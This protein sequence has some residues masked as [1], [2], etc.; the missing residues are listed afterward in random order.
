MR[1]LCI[2]ALCIVLLLCTAACGQTVDEPYSAAFTIRPPES[3]TAVYFDTPYVSE[4]F[5][6]RDDALD[7]NALRELY[8]GSLFG[9]ETEY[10]ARWST[11]LLYALE[12]EFTTQDAQTMSAL[13]VELARTDGFPGMRET[14]AA[15]ANVHIRFQKSD[16]PLF[17]YDA[18]AS[19]RIRSVEITVPSAYLP[20]QRN[21]IVR[22][23]MMRGCGFFQTV[24]TTLDSVLAQRP[25]SDLR[26][27][28][29]I[30]LNI[31]YGGVEP[32]ADKAA[33]LAAFDQFFSGE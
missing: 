8:I 11:P 31:L 17:R 2:G 25:A 6:V 16:T 9:A 33:C 3:L 20:V 12:G 15:D 30:L 23:Y 5:V 7:Y 21:A 22:Q 13:A 28:D 27:A 24:Q 29:F 26:D 19:G 10:A 14:A 32:G 1:K 4:T 18:D